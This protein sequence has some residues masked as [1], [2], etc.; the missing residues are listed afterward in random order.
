MGAAAF[1]FSGH[2]CGIWKFPGQGSNSNSICDLYHSCGNAGALTPFARLGIEPVPPQRQGRNPNLLCCSRNSKWEHPSPRLSLS[3]VLGSLAA[4]L[5][6][7]MNTAETSHQPQRPRGRWGAT[8]ANMGRGRN[9]KR[10]VPW[11][12]GGQDPG[13]ALS[14]PSQH[15]PKG[16]QAVHGGGLR[17]PSSSLQ[18]GAG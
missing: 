16:Q 12:P 6:P 10:Q 18:A 14:P 9:K 17:G 7:L 3:P 4:P 1:F 11:G 2:T 13:A 8:L 5:V 15:V